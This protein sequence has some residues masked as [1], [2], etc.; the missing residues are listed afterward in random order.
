MELSSAQASQGDTNTIHLATSTSQGPS[1]EVGRRSVV[2]EGTSVSVPSLDRN[3]SKNGEWESGRPQM[4]ASEFDDEVGSR[5]TGM[6]TMS[7]PGRSSPPGGGQA[8]GS[9]S[10]NLVPSGISSPRTLRDGYAICN[11]GQCQLSWPI[12]RSLGN[13]R[14]ACDGEFR[15][16][17]DGKIH[18]QFQTSKNCPYYSL[19]GAVG[20]GRVIKHEASC[21]EAEVGDDGVIFF[22]CRY[23]PR[24]FQTASRKSQHERNFCPN[25]PR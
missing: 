6:P 2:V 14:S 4:T 13:H 19:M 16:E 5:R 9:R 21:T 18:C 25:Q 12:K 23:C 3:D 11:I 20:F 8:S 22:S 17:V 24:K 10:T 15:L 7:G 1:G